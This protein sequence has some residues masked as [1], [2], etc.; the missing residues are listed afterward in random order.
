VN[1]IALNSGNPKVDYRRK[2][3]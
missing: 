1:G 2:F 3:F